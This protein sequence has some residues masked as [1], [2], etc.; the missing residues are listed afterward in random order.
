MCIRDRIYA[1]WINDTSRKRSDYMKFDSKFEID[2]K[3]RYF[4]I[5][6]KRIYDEKHR[7]CLLYTSKLNNTDVDKVLNDAFSGNF[8]YGDVYSVHI[9]ALIEH[10]STDVKLKELINNLRYVEEKIRNTA[11][12]DIVSVTEKRIEEMCIR[13]RHNV[14]GAVRGAGLRFFR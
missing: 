8:K 2:G 11:A 13:D 14:D 3:T 10:F 9:K 6:Y 12:H 4:D 7:P 5:S 1:Q